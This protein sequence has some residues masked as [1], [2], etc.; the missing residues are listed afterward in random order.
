MIRLAGRT[1]AQFVAA[2]F[3]VIG[4]TRRV[5]PQTPA[6]SV[7]QRAR[8]ADASSAYRV[9]R[10]PEGIRLDGSLS[11]PSWRA[12]DSIVDFRQREPLGGAPASERTVVKVVRD[13]QTIYIGVRAYDG[14]MPAVR[15]S[16]LRRDADLSSDDNVTILIDSYRDRRSAFLFRTNP[17]GAMW[18]AQ[19]VGL[20]NLNENWNG[21]WEVVTRRDSDSWTA[22]F[23][24]PLRTLRIK[25]GA[26]SIGFNVRRFIRRKN[27]EDLWR[28]W[29]R[30]QGSDNLL[31]TGDIAGFGDV[32]RDH[33]VELR[34]Y[35]LARAVEPSYD[36][37]G[38]R[39]GAGSTD[40][41]VGLDAKL[42]VSPT[43]T[44]DLTLNTDFAQVEADQQVINLTRFPTFFPEKREFFLE[45][46]GLFDIGTPGRVQLFY[47]RR[48]GL[49]STGVPVPILAGARVYGKGGPWAVGVLDTRTGGAERANDVAVRVGRDV[50]DR[51][52]IAA[53]IVDRTASHL[54][55]RGAGVDLDFPL[56][57]RGHN[58][59]P[60]FWL[61]GTHT[62][63]APGTPLAWRV[64]TD[65]PNDLFDNFVSLYRIDSG[66]AP[67]M[68]F[69]RRTGV[70][71]T[72]G[73][74]DYMPRPG[75]FGIRRFDLTPIPSWDI[76][77]D[78]STGDV[79]RPSTWQ[80]ADFE[81]H[82]LAGDL[83]S[84]DRF[85]VNVVR[86]LDAPTSSFDIFRNVTIAPGRYWW[87]S[88]NVQ[89]ETNPGRP[90]GVGAILSTGQFY[91]GRSSAAELSSTLHAGGHVILSAGYA[92]TSAHISSG[93]FTATQ[94]NSHLE[95][96]FSTRV[97]FL[98]F[99]QFENEDRRADFNLRFHW[100]P[101]IGDDVFVV[102]NSG[103]TTEPDAPW[104]FPGRGALSHPLNGAFVVKAV[105]R[106]AR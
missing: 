99:V 40:G 21:I 8:S 102:W 80:T 20:D 42:G 87:T 10:A 23:A 17:N 91:D 32:P 81:W 39:L 15:A 18:D 66:F 38:V 5:L 34:P 24:I 76:I 50:F 11:G 106:L 49:D 84:G 51:S 68:G 62:A 83:Q 2:A 85:E 92:V 43:M 31:N 1:R 57:V 95:Y 36:S 103:F 79:T 54:A 97:D 101:K 48:I 27:E 96:A 78:R 3:L 53:M 7:S 105:H 56:V 86:D 14:D 88:G 47:S 55:E 41:K 33:S 59:E 58:V 72:T 63:A 13:A 52:T 71:E 37:S 44:A 28:S 12:A 61:I 64:S 25:P 45:S 77:A 74:V 70:W 93:Q 65:Y 90:I 98:G 104:R 30:V 9:Q 6:G 94:L 73:H 67:T 46:S 89:Y 60:H 29:G 35:V 19:L 100:I 26:D 16:Q 4:L 22:E 75:A 82:L 69:V